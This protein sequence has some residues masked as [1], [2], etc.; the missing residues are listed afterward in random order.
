M[1]QP[2]IRGTEGSDDVHDDPFSLL[3]DAADDNLAIHSRDLAGDKDEIAC[4]HRLGERAPGASGRVV[5]RVKTS[6]ADLHFERPSRC[7]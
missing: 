6:Y 5:G 1:F 7:K 2:A 3:N 4:T